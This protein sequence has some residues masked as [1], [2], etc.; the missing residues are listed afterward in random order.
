MTRTKT[1]AL[2]AGSLAVAHSL[3]ALTSLGPL[4][5]LLAPGSAARATPATWR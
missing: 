4:R 3:P 2:A 5:P 1:L